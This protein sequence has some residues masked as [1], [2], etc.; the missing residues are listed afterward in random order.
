MKPKLCWLLC[1]GTIFMTP[2]QDE[3][4]ESHAADLTAEKLRRYFPGLDNTVDL[5][6]DDVIKVKKTVD[7]DSSNLTPKDWAKIASET[8]A[9]LNRGYDGVLITH[10]T[11]SMHYTSAALSFMLKGLDRT[12]AL[13]GA[14]RPAG[15]VDSDAPRNV[16]DAARMAADGEVGVYIAFGGCFIRGVRAR[17]VD[18]EKDAAFEEFNGHDGFK[19]PKK[20][21]PYRKV[22]C[23][24]AMDFKVGYIKAYPGLNPEILDWY[25]DQS[26]RGI[27]IEGLGAGHVN[28][29]DKACSFLPALRRAKEA[30]IPVF[31]CTQCSSGAVKLVYDVGLKLAQAGV[32]GLGD[33]L[34]E[35]AVVKLMHA[36]A[37]YRTAGEI[38]DAMK[39]NMAGEIGVKQTAVSF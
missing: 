21:K 2:N 23:D 16:L 31:M 1:G 38:V 19:P 12:V 7:K 5:T 27:V 8:A 34:G 28:S 39:N 33:M 10:G 11:D 15:T 4:L 29:Q 6:E 17:K 37:H 32:V 24:S 9:A 36:A 30:D 3:M 25:I 14:Q 13:T 20:D 35:V 18:T 22:E 26:Y